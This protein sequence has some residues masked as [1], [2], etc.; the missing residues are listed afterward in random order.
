MNKNEITQIAKDMKY[1]KNK[2]MFEIFLYHNYKFETGNSSGSINPFSY[3]IINTRYVINAYYIALVKH[4]NEINIEAVTL[5]DEFFNKNFIKNHI[6]TVLCILKVIPNIS[7]LINSVDIYELIDFYSEILIAHCKFSEEAVD[8]NIKSTLQ[9]YSKAYDLLHNFNPK[10]LFNDNEL[11]YVCDTYYKLY[12]PFYKFASKEE[13]SL[14][15]Y[16]NVI[17]S[18]NDD[19]YKISSANFETKYNKL[20]EIFKIVSQISN[21]LN[22]DAE[23]I[24][25]ALYRYYSEKEIKA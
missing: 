7:L 17:D 11:E 1:Y 10:K 23:C 8:N 3:K 2:N 13:S 18:L 24:I 22:T 21:N 6:D 12:T 19:I 25:K 14:S 5:Y 20:L 15:F 9:E 4:S 16:K